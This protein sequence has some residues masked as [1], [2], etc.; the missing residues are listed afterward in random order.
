MLVVKH[1]M[2]LT[3]KEQL[4]A[5]LK[6]FI[7]KGRREKI[8]HLAPL[9]SRYVTA[10][11]ENPYHSHNISAVLR[12]ME[13]LGLQD[14]HIIE[15]HHPY[16]ITNGVAK[17]AGKW[18]DI[19]R[20]GQAQ[21]D[22]AARCF[23]RLKQDGYRIVATAPTDEAYTPHTLPLD[24]KTALIFGTEIVGISEYMYRNAD[25]TLAIPMYGFT[26]SFNISVSTA[27]CMYTLAERMRHSDHNWKLPHQDQLDIQLSWLRAT[28]P[29]VASYEQAFFAR[30]ARK[31]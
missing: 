21:E 26:E 16:V 25:M 3:D 10:A 4:V 1:T 9:R 28:I 17:G 14:V 2:D 11:L 31:K 7:T 27:I 22:N 29:R 19:H 5:Y 15:E 13:C 8:E 6:Q 12:S 30:S 18:L 23:D 24:H 20:Y